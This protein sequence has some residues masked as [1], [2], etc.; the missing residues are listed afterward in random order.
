MSTI[1]EQ[2]QLIYRAGYEDRAKERDYDP[3]NRKIV[4]DTIEALKEVTRNTLSLIEVCKDTLDETTYQ[5]LHAAL[6]KD[7]RA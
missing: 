6:T 4:C 1:T 5:E 7:L 2:V 3:M